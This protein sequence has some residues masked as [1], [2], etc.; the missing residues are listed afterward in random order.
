M[1]HRL[2]RRRRLQ[3]AGEKPGQERRCHDQGQDRASHV[4]PPALLDLDLPEKRASRAKYLRQPGFRRP[5]PKP[6]GWNVIGSATWRLAWREETRRRSPATCLQQRHACRN[7][8]DS[9]SEQLRRDGFYPE[10]VTPLR[11]ADRAALA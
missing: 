11:A 5:P 6:N 4:S 7:C 8:W 10:P 2:D 3:V 9:P 1:Q